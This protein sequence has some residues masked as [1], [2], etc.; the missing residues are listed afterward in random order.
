MPDPG[1]AWIALGIIAGA[2]VISLPPSRRKLFIAALKALTAQHDQA[3]RVVA[4]GPRTSRE[5]AI[6]HAVLGGTAWI[7]RLVQEI[8][9]TAPA[10]GHMTKGGQASPS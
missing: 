4:F 9:R 10:T 8:E 3:E 2:L 5:K 7:R 1:P 6:S